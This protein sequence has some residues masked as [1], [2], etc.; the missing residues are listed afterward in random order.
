MELVKNEVIKEKKVLITWF[1]DGR[2][3]DIQA[4]GF[5]NPFDIVQ[6]L[7]IVILSIQEKVAKQS[8]INAPGIFIPQ[9]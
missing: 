1:G 9:H 8:R 4:H 3:L 2:P 5:D 6:M 7:S